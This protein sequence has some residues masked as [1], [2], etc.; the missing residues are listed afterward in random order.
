MFLPSAYSKLTPVL[1]DQALTAAEE[2]REAR[3]EATGGC[4]TG[5]IVCDE[6]NRVNVNRALLNRAPITQ[7]AQ[8]FGYTRKAMLSHIYEHLNPY[9]PEF[10]KDGLKRLTKEE[11]KD[12]LHK[13]FPLRGSDRSKMVW[14]T[15]QLMAMKTDLTDA[16]DDPAHEPFQHGKQLIT[17]LREM[18]STILAAADVR[19]DTAKPREVDITPPVD[20]GQRKLA[21]Q[22]HRQQ[23]AE[24]EPIGT[25]SPTPAPAETNAQAI[26]PDALHEARAEADESP[27]AAG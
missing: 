22:V 9:I 23:L 10:R 20:P 17:V 24:G 2:A 7:V 13:P 21:M 1:I 19:K 3:F 14:L 18:R 26:Q 12:I 16:F 4:G 25:F 6:P 27:E 5:C 11:T 15:A 8:A